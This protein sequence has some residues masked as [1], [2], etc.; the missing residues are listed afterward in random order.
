MMK[1]NRIV[2]IFLFF[3]STIVNSYAA[4]LPTDFKQ[5]NIPIKS[6]PNENLKD[7]V[8]VWYDA[9][10]SMSGFT[11]SQPEEVNL[12]G[13][14][15]NSLQQASQS[16][17]TETSYNTFGSRFQTIDENRASL[18]TTQEFYKCTQ[19]AQTCV[20]K[21]RINGLSKVL[22]VAKKHTDSTIIIVTDLFVSTSETLAKNAE[23]IK[24]PLTA[25]FN[26]G[27]S[28]GIFGVS[29]SYNGKISGIPTE[30]GLGYVTYSKATKRPF[31]IIVIGSGKNINF[32]EEKLK[33][34]QK[35]Q[36]AI[37]ENPDAY[38]FTMITSNVI[39]EN[40]N[41]NKKIEAKN[42]TNISSQSEGYK[43]EYKENLPIYEFITSKSNFKLKFDNSDFIV[44]GSSVAEY[45][46]VQELW[47]LRGSCKKNSK[48]GKSNR[49]NFISVPD[50]NDDTLTLN[51]FE[52]KKLNWGLRWFVLAEVYTARNGS[53]SQDDFKD[54][55]LTD[56]SAAS[57]MQ[58]DPKFFKTLNLMTIIEMI[59]DVA[60]E[61]FKPTKVASIAM[62][63]ELEK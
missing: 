63:F 30:D 49:K 9:S 60:T 3:L 6:S 40:L 21:D 31:Y 53:S 61:E 13:P 45:K 12:F 4:C 59:D 55:D 44:Q 56:S 17:G 46:I 50:V 19:S 43:F 33:K 8:H 42:L 32:I 47:S 14:I 28:V 51:F 23:R 41:T 26:N 27:Q 29:S 39:S 57:H 1:F 54:W 11:K 52:E 5:P 62:N 34:N 22:S 58:S 25:I 48:W 20:T 35:L 10:L 38:K 37:A 36:D 2:L 15:L 16:L 18:V 7:K 24:K